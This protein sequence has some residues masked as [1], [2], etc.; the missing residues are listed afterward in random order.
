MTKL[1][2][3]PTTMYL[4]AFIAMIILSVLLELLGAFLWVNHRVP[5]YPQE[6]ISGAIG[7]IAII[8]IFALVP[9]SAF[10][11]RSKFSLSG[12]CKRRALVFGVSLLTAVGVTVYM[13]GSL[14]AA[15]I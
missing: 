6:I 9:I 1:K 11:P 15:A 5:T 8:G 2:D 14:Y 3:V 12:D 7:W 4:G 13:I 10:R